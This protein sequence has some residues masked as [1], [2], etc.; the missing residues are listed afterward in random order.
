MPMLSAA[1]VHELARG[2]G[3]SDKEAN[4]MT[5]IAPCE[6]GNAGKYPVNSDAENRNSNGSVDTGIW[7]I[8]S[9]HRPKHPT[10]TVAWLKVPA[11]NAK[12]MAVLFRDGGVTPWTSSGSCWL[13]KM[14][15]NA[16]AGTLADPKGAAEAVAGAVGNPVDTALS[17]VRALVETVNRVGSW[18]S[19]PHSWTRVGYV[20]A[21]IALVIAAGAAVAADTK[22]G[23]AVT[24]T[25]TTIATRRPARR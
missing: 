14:T 10:W 21:G 2:A 15:E 23:Q 22:A 17:A 4:T 8:N 25:A 7:Q 13:P 3:L 9:V 5:V 11:N 6:S 20:A 1:Q 16:L 24:G 12:A 18:I 19:D